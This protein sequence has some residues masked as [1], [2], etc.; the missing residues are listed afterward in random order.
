MTRDA[1]SVM[2]LTKTTIIACLVVRTGTSCTDERGY[3][4]SDSE[5]L[6]QVLSVNSRLGAYPNYV[7]EG[8]R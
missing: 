5:W 8:T 7:T 6:S 2:T 3:L 1:I 4:A